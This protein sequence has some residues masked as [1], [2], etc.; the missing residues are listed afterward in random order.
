[1]KNRSLK[2]YDISIS[3]YVPSI[4]QN[5]VEI[6]NLEKFPNLKSVIICLEDSILDSQVKDGE[7][8]LQNMLN[9][10]SDKKI[11]I[12]VRAR[13]FEHFKK[14]LDFPNIEKI[15]GFVIPKFDL[16]NIEKYLPFFKNDFYFMPVIE[17]KESFDIVKLNKIRDILL[18]Y[19]DSIISIRI[20]SEDIGNILN[21]KR[22]CGS[23]I[24]DIPIFSTVI[25]NIIS[26]FK[27][28][29]FNV[30]APVFS[31]Y[32]DIELFEKELKIDIQNGLIGKTL[33]H[34]SQIE[35]MTNMYKVSKKQLDE[36][37]QS[38]AITNSAVL[39]LNGNMIETITHKNWAE[40][41]IIRSKIYGIK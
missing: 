16:D 9:N 20:G 22:E 26:A 13:N 5:L 38:L 28:Y 11:A 40:E 15:D 7:K 35:I 30:T 6:I 32:K 29:N 23:I 33:I 21:I 12:F 17:G 36:A 4:N 41:I 39:G 14:V 19:V 34:P 31:C 1:V 3:L 8:N 2:Y 37:K 18:G 10:L 27:P 25:T 24:Y